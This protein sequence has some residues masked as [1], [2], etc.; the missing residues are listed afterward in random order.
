MDNLLLKELC[1]RLPHGVMV[2]RL[3]T[4]Y[5][6]LSVKQVS[7]DF[8]VETDKGGYYNINEVKPMLRPISSMTDEE[9]SKLFQILEIKEDDE[10]EWLK[11]NDIGIIRLFTGSGKDFYQIDEALDYLCSIHIDYRG[12]IEK[13]LAL[14]IHKV[15]VNMA[16]KKY[17]K[18]IYKR[19]Q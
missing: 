15:K 13:G 7:N 2:D 4:T 17:G 12:L 5:K 1:R 9:I 14:E 10:K 16:E 3:G 8:Y 11:I 6:L 19:T 18:K